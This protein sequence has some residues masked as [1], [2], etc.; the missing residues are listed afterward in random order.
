MVNKFTIIYK[1]LLKDS[2]CAL[3]FLSVFYFI[4]TLL[5]FLHIILI[6]RSP[7]Y[8]QRDDYGS[9]K[10]I[11]K[12]P[13]GETDGTIRLYRKYLILL[14]SLSLCA[15]RAIPLYRLLR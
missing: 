12:N 11:A 5:K 13:R 8:F 7:V 3:Y 4:I 15:P 14:L 9:Y 10:C 1:K 6:I 2:S